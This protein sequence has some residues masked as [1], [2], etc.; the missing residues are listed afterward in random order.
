MTLNVGAQEQ[1]KEK[2]NDHEYKYKSEDLK[3]KLQQDETKVKANDLKIKDNENER[4]VKA[5]VKPMRTSATE[6]TMMKTGETQV[7]TKD[8]LAPISSES[9]TSEP[10][11]PAPVAVQKVAVPKNAATVKRTTAR[12]YA[13]SKRTAN[14]RTVARKAKSSPKYIVRTKLVRDTVYVPGPTETVLAKQ[15]E[16]VHDTVFVTRVDTV[17]RMQTKN[18]Y[19]G[20]QVPKGD[21]KKVKLKRDKDGEVWMKRKE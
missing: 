6:R 20:Y 17:I 7:R 15:T 13:A 5:K 11:V 2:I 8:H 9:V 19:S 14:R 10:A 21:F 16:Y 18:T 3:V 4:K 12:K 1:P